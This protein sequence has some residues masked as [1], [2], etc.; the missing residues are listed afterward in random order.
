MYYVFE[1][2]FGGKNMKDRYSFYYQENNKLFNDNILVI[3]YNATEEEIDKYGL[4]SN[5]IIIFIKS[6]ISNKLIKE[7]DIDYFKVVPKLFEKDILFRI[8]S[9]CLLGMY[10]DSHCDCENQ[11][12]EF[13]NLLK[14]KDGIFIHVPQE[15]QGW[16][17]FYKCKELEIQVNGRNQNGKFIGKMNRDDAQKYLI[18]NDKFEDKRSYKLIY[19]ILEDLK[20]NDKKYIVYTESENKINNLIN[21]GLNA[22]K[23]SEY[24]KEN[25]TSENASEYLIKILNETHKYSKDIVD[26]LCEIIKKRKY[27]DRTLSTLID[28][29]SR[30]NN[31]KKF[32]IDSYT[33]KTILEAYNEIICG[34]ERNYILKYSSIQKKQNKFTCEV[35]PLIFKQLETINKKNIFDRICFEQMYYFLNTTNLDIKKIRTSKVL[36]INDNQSAFFIGQIYN[37]ERLISNEKKNIVEDT[38][39]SSKVKTMF[40]NSDFEYAKYQE[41]ITFISEDEIPGINVYIKRIPNRQNYV[42]DVYGKKENIHKFIE[43]LTKQK[44]LALLSFVNNIKLEDD[45]Y[46]DYNLR[47][48]DLELVIKEELDNFREMKGK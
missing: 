18:K 35:N 13:I 46:S 12:K 45:N 11:K 38:T 25:I 31:D 1:A 26:D 48:S 47:F 28:I 15:A 44:V 16:G 21:C 39:S 10:G 4:T 42:M 27:N 34:E 41:M 40:E 9:E 33:K 37:I 23:Y 5:N 43:K 19:N 8:Q 24:I 14:D 22:I 3:C 6:K 2:K 29:V 7:S 17:L 30:I 36:D 20:L 32:T